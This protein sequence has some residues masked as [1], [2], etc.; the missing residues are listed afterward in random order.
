MRPGFGVTLLFG[1]RHHLAWSRLVMRAKED[2]QSTVNLVT[3]SHETRRSRPRAGTIID[4]HE[5]EYRRPRSAAGNRRKSNVDRGNKISQHCPP[6]DSPSE[7]RE[8]GG[9]GAGAPTACCLLRDN[10]Q[11][12]WCIPC[13]TVCY[14]FAAN[15]CHRIDQ[16]QLKLSK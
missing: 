1:V 13:Y 5:I 11:R 4:S 12:A 14:Q 6:T 9:R 16:M 2:P 15:A 7:G 10:H 3:S 8:R